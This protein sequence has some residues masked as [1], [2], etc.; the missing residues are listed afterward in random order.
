MKSLIYAIIIFALSLSVMSED[1]W[2]SFPIPQTPGITD[3]VVT[4]LVTT[5]DGRVFMVS[6]CGFYQFYNNEWT[7][8][9]K[10]TP[11][12][13]GNHAN[14]QSLTY[15]PNGIIWGASEMGFMKYTIA[16]GT[17]EYLDKPTMSG[18]GSDY[19]YL[20]G[21]TLD[22]KN[23]LW[24][25]SRTPYLS[26]FDGTTFTDWDICYVN[27]ILATNFKSATLLADNAGNIWITGD[28]GAMKVSTNSTADSL[29]YQKFT[30]EDMY[31]T[32]GQVLTICL[33]K[34]GYI[35]ASSRGGEIS[36][37]N[38]TAW[39]N[40]PIPI[41]MKGVKDEY[42]EAF[43]NT[44]VEDKSGDMLFYWGCAGFYLSYSSDGILTKNQ[45]PAEITDDNGVISIFDAA[46]DN[47]G[48]LLLGTYGKS[49]VKYSKT[50]SINEKEL[51]YLTLQ[52]I[53]ALD[54]ID[55]TSIDPELINQNRTR[56]YISIYNS[57][58]ELVKDN[59]SVQNLPFR[60]NISDFSSGV[61]FIKAG[62]NYYRFVKI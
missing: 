25:I 45:F 55:I 30:L 22:K 37:Y 38:G 41:E 27:K 23:N 40:I 51:S 49:L 13:D 12:N 54:Y 61:Y 44:I 18:S 39:V 10:D 28:D 43:I 48:N 8:I 4:N 31:F 47:N 24:F 26:K 62:Y 36:Y 42:G 6:G 32:K 1:K 14:I 9:L 56:A 34:K 17:I 35:W 19:G 46:I 20:N 50:T 58:G 29:N 59:I 21:L 57:L 3:N 2:E 60:L 33:D 53:P 11:F 15:D 5:P 7:N 52:P 16:T